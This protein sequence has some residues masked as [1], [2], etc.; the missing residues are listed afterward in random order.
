[1][2]SKLLL[3]MA[4]PVAAAVAFALVV[5]EVSAAQSNPMLGTWKL[6]L[7]KSKYNP[8]PAPKSLT[9]VVAASGQGTVANTEGVNAQGVPTK[10]TFVI[11]CDGQPHPV[12]GAPNVD[13]ISCRQ[14]DPY[15]QQFINMK[16]GKAT[17]SGT[18]VVSRDGKTTT[19]STKGTTATGQQV[20]NVAVYD[21]Q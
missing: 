6:N 16:S 15:T 20:D 9:A 19:I 14:P 1:M 21:K 8:G 3:T 5:P 4:A 18:L 2:T 7:A 12:T 13:A 10:T 11:I 17:T